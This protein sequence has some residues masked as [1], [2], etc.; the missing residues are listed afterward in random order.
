MTRLSAIL[1]TFIITVLLVVLS[2]TSCAD[3]NIS[4]KL[5][6]G[7]LN[8]KPS[9]EIKAGSIR[10]EWR[11]SQSLWQ[12][13]E[14]GVWSD[15]NRSGD[16]NNRRLPAVHVEYQIGVRPSSEHFFVGAFSGVMLML[17]P[18][19]VLGGAGQFVHDLMVG[20]K[21]DRAF[22]GVGYR[23]ISSAGIFRP[24]KG[25][26]FILFSMGVTW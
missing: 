8:G 26:D 14:G 6:L 18:D 25:R 13:V 20:F 7:L 4:F 24:N 12:A 9:S 15:T 19:A 17:P 3:D 5:G 10:D 23:H 2:R 16:P 11:L 21:D 22:V 1:W